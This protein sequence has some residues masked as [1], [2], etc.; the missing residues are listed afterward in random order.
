MSTE[1][2]TTLLH[3]NVAQIETLIENVANTEN[4][5]TIRNKVK[6]AYGIPTA[7]NTSLILGL[8]A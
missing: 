5:D 2:L 7:P 6:E 1:H 8:V 3:L 4:K